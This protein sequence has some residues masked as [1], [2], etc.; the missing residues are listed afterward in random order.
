MSP[1]EDDGWGWALGRTTRRS[2]QHGGWE[3]GSMGEGK[4]RTIAEGGRDDERRRPPTALAP[5]PAAAVAAAQICDDSD[6]GTE[7]GV[8]TLSIK[9]AMTRVLDVTFCLLSWPCL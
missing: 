1:Q 3:D 5:A 7:I 4:T 2:R 9:K 8:S 6:K